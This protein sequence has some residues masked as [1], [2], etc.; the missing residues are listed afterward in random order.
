MK[1]FSIYHL[2]FI[3]G[4]N[5]DKFELLNKCKKYGLRIIKLSQEIKEF[6]FYSL[7]EQIMRSG[8]SIGANI[9]EAQSA[10]SKKEFV[11]KINIALK[12]ARE[13]KYWLE[14][15]TDSVPIKGNI[16]EQLIGETDEIIAILFSIIRTTKRKYE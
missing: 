10:Y 11:M 15:V 7:G 6:K 3:P 13:T 16:I 9:N 4:R 14:L 1:S 12:E 8:T 2:T 5:L